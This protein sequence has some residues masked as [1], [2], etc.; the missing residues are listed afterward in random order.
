MHHIIATWYLVLYTN[1]LFSMYI[2]LCR[3]N[4]IICYYSCKAIHA[5]PLKCTPIYSSTI[6]NIITPRATIPHYHYHINALHSLMFFLL[7]LHSTSSHY[8]PQIIIIISRHKVAIIH[9]WA[10][11]F[12]HLLQHLTTQ[13]PIITIYN[14]CYTSLRELIHLHYITTHTTEHINKYLMTYRIYT[15]C[16]LRHILLYTISTPTIIHVV[17]TLCIST[18]VF[19]YTIRTARIYIVLYTQ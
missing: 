19:I 7:Y 6:N 16:W 13:Y 15:L 11:I 12:N 1:N 2:I 4:D 10:D 14:I 17:A 3:W 8:Q 9:W 5:S 18:H